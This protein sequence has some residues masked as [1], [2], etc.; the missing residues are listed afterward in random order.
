MAVSSAD[1]PTHNINQEIQLSER[2]P[3]EIQSVPG[4]SYGVDRRFSLRIQNCFQIQGSPGDEQFGFDEEN[5]ISWTRIQVEGSEQCIVR[6]F[7]GDHLI[8][9]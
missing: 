4:T 2:S 1:S 7:S 3:D 8:P 9:D 5:G 6:C